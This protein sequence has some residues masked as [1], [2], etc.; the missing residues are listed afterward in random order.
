MPPLPTVVSKAVPPA[1]TNCWPSALIVVPLAKPPSTSSMPP[2]TTVVPIAVPR[3][4]LSRPATN[5]LLIVAPRGTSRVP[6]GQALGRPVRRQK[7]RDVYLHEAPSRA[8]AYARPRDRWTDQ[9]ARFVLKCSARR[10]HPRCPILNGDLGM[11]R[12]P[13]QR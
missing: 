11:P 3:K 13:R 12:F 1:P 5:V 9:K 2:P 4:T 10:R 6:P 7:A 8:N